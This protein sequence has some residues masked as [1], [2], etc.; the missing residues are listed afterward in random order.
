M[1]FQLSS[2]EDALKVQ[3][4]QE[5]SI[6]VKI[7]EMGDVITYHNSQKQERKYFIIKAADNKD[8]INIRNYQVRNRVTLNA[9]VSYAFLGLLRKMG[10]ECFWTTKNTNIVEWVPV[11]V[12]D[13]IHLTPVK[14]PNNSPRKLSEAIQ[15]GSTSLIKGKVVQVMF[16]KIKFM[17]L[18]CWKPKI[19][20]IVLDSAFKRSKNHCMAH[21]FCH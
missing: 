5:C 12:P 16:M 1:S 15:S 21:P 9:G 10:D 7:L 19:S 2:I 3:P 6:A 4:D 14:S 18:L 8:V 11:E 20:V 17:Q 13:N